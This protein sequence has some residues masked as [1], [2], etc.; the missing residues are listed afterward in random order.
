MGLID[1]VS[2]V[3]RENLDII[4]VVL[5]ADTKKDRTRD[6]IRLIEYTFQNY[7][8]FDIKRKIEEEF[9]NWKNINEKRIKISKGVK[10]NPEI[11]LENL[12]YN[13]IALK[14]GEKDNIKIDIESINSFD[15]PLEKNTCIGKIKCYI[16]KNEQF[17]L[18]ILNE[19]RVEKK[20]VL[21]Y[22]IELLQW[23]KF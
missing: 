8:I 19:Y 3:K 20:N 9:I 5:G 7:E 4:C 15:A 10:E 2:S 16:N 6:S 23:Y 11:I 1:V 21:N 12:P 18:Q 17:E 13:K 22:F 14:K